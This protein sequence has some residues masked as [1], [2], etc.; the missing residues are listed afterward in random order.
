MKPSP[1]PLQDKRL[2]ALHSF[3]ILDTDPEKDFDDIVKLASAICG[4]PISMISLVDADRQWFKARVGV[5]MT[6]TPLETSI[7]A[8]AILEAEFLEIADTTQDPRIADNTL[9]T[10]DQGV[11]FYA[12]AALKTADNLPIGT[13]CVL[14]YQPKELSP[15]QRDTLKVLARQVM[16]QL[17]M[18]KAL[19]TAHL[20]R[21]E[22]DHR[23]KNSLQSLSALIRIQ[24]RALT[25]P[26]AKDALASI[27]SRLDAVATLHELL[28]K[29]EADANVDLG[30]YVQT[31][32]EHLSDI[33]PSGVTITA[34]PLHVTVSTKQAVAVGTLV[35]EFIANSL[36]HAFP[37]H[38]EGTVKV[39]L[40]LAERGMVRVICSD[41]GV[42]FAKGKRLRSGG[43]GLKIAEVACMEL[44][45]K[46]VFKRPAKGVSIQ[47]DFQPEERRA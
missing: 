34:T 28:Y 12:G 6:E 23:M 37:D 8:H 5:D 22:V 27:K 30:K 13:L 25:S 11:R 45:A 36:K 44:P 1:H 33:A 35:N 18:R 47:F 41:N 20:L 39:S 40:S 32:C 14:D 31:I 9:V 19:H 46:L 4:T 29:T 10:I 15:L 3:E 21:Q 24:S 43:L 42:G 16:T 26:E 38:S 17:E 2:S 7:C